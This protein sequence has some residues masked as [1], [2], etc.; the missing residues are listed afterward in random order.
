LFRIPTYN[1]CCICI[2]RFW[3]MNCNYSARHLKWK[4][5]RERYDQILREG[6]Q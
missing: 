6:L 2:S 4:Q 3:I 1:N 5:Y